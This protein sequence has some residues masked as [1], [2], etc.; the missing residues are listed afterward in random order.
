MMAE[1]ADEQISHFGLDRAEA[2]NGG[3][4][5]V[6]GEP[7]QRRAVSAQRRQY[8]GEVERLLRNL[9]WIELRYTEQDG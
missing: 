2:E 9:G 7:V 8:T 1:E 5:I 6:A 4:V 3:D